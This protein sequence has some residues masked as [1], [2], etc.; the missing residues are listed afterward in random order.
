MEGSVKERLL[1]FLKEKN[2]SQSEFAR[3]L[4]VAP[5]YI[6]AMRK[7]MPS[8]KMR[9]IGEIF[10]DLNRDWLLYG[11]GSM[12]L[13]EQ[14]NEYRVPLLPVE[15]FAG[16]LQDWSCGVRKDD[17]PRIVSPTTS[18]DFAIRITG[19]SM[20]P[21]FHSGMILFI[22]RI[23]DRAFIPWGNP[24]VVDTE[25][26]VL[27]KVLYPAT[28]APAPVEHL[29]RNDEE[30]TDEGTVS[31]FNGSETAIEAR[32]YNEHYPPIRIPSESI[33]GIYR[34]L[35]AVQEFSTI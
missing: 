13:G 31:V 15:A 29:L 9:K 6:G 28:S 33:Y 25:N 11:D 26:G 10:P 32:S 16:R 3:R 18:A 12:Y 24:M 35:T 27:V 19:D 30:R 7:S 34:V 20:E 23:N 1:R 5:T 21:V 14:E 8:D 22:K 17:C 2:M 4:G